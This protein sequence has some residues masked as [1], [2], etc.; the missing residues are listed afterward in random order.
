M[1]SNIKSI[2][3][4]VVLMASTAMGVAQSSRSGY[5]TEGYLYRYQ[6][7]PAIANDRNFIAMPGVGNL[8]VGVNGTLSLDDV[9][10][11]VDGQTTTFLNPAVDT[12]EFLDAISDKNRLGMDVKIGIL[13]AG[14]KGFKGY[15][16]ISL[17]VR[18]N[19]QMHMPG[20]LFRLL[21]EG[22]ENKTYDISD[23]RAHADAY[24]E[25]AL[26]HSHKLNDQWRIGGAV[27]FLVGAGNVDAELDKAYLTLGE[28]SWNVA[29]D[30]KMQSS[31]KGLT[32][33]HD[34]NNRT[35][36]EY[37]DGFD[38]DGAGVNGFG[39]AFDLGAQFFLNKDWTFSAS[40]LDL[41]FINWDN[42]MLASTN[43]LQEFATD[44][45]S[46][47]VDDEASN[48]FENEW[49]VMRDDL[50]ALYELNDMGD[51]GARSKMLAATINLAAQYNLPLYRKLAF[52]LLN[53]TRLQGEYSWTEFRLSANVS[54][55]KAFSAGANVAV[56]TYGCA[57]G[58]IVNLNAPGVNIFVGMD[59][60]LTKLAK[61]GVPLSSNA[62][63]NLGIN[64]AF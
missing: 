8:N 32:Y 2:I 38:I 13:S 35:G 12:N 4:I 64:I 63:A 57:F 5:F 51:Q 60:T 21:K 15:N 6:M 9:I 40:V 41:G 62:S 37:V 23:F 19:V 58:W 20:S 16:T 47:N 10:Y 26:G 14:F 44:K 50:S 61:Q 52:G 36:H 3:S 46:F 45:Y 31:I 25:L 54:P 55:A 34:V 53:T 56:G 39:V 43:G 49:D 29:V 42:N 18:T 27:K 11:N 28:N 48:S 30:G 17:N 59:H 24:A 1:K 33:E 22:V 7:N